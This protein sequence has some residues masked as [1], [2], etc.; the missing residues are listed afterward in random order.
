MKKLIGNTYSEIAVM[1]I[2]KCDNNTFI[3]PD[4]ELLYHEND[5]YGASSF[6]YLDLCDL[7]TGKEDKVTRLYVNETKETYF[8]IWDLIGVESNAAIVKEYVVRVSGNT[9]IAENVITFIFEDTAVINRLLKSRLNRAYGKYNFYK[10]GVSPTDMYPII[11]MPHGAG[12]KYFKLTEMSNKER[13]EWLID[14]SNDI[15]VEVLRKE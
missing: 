1:F 10:L 14:W 7:L 12:R 3:Y 9:R 6:R 4:H 11:V 15:K 13:L 8:Y 2:P 5:L